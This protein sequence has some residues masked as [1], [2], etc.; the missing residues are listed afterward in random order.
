MNIEIKYNS[1]LQYLD[2][3]VSRYIYETYFPLK[4]TK[5]WKNLVNDQF[6]YFKNKYCNEVYKLENIYSY[7]TLFSPRR[8][9]YKRLT[10]N[11]YLIMKRNSNYKKNRIRSGVFQSHRRAI[12]YKR[13]A[14]RLRKK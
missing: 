14:N 5:Q 13:E 4:I 3:D 10:F 11:A 2:Y 9:I 8:H 1:P 7:N 12:T 6:K